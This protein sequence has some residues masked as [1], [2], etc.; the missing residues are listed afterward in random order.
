VPAS[1]LDALVPSDPG[2]FELIDRINRARLKDGARPVPL[3]GLDEAVLNLIFEVLYSCD[4]NLQLCVPGGRQDLATALGIY[5]Q[6]DRRGR[7]MRQGRDPDDLDGPIV[8]LGLNLNVTERLRR[9]RLGTHNLSE[10]LVVGR[11]RGDGNVIGLAGVPS[12]ARAWRH[13]LL[14][15][16]TSLGY[17][18]LAQ[19]RPEVAIID[20]TTLRRPESLARALDWC[21]RQEVRRILLLSEL[22]SEAAAAL[23]VD[24]SWCTFPLTPAILRDVRQT[25][26]VRADGGALST[27]ALII[28]ARR[29]PSAAV[30]RAPA[31]A[32]AR[33]NALSAI[34]A[35]RRIPAPKPQSIQNAV[36]LVNA[37][38]GLW[39]N[40]ATADRIAVEQGRSFSVTGMTR[41][42][43]SDLGRDLHG[44]WATFRETRWTDLRRACLDLAGLVFEENPRLALLQQLLAWA[45]ANRPGATICIRTVSRSGALALAEDLQAVGVGAA[46][47]G[48]GQGPLITVRP[49]GERRP[50]SSTPALEFHLG[51][52]PPW[53]RAGIFA[54]SA[55][56]HV[57]ALEQDEVPWFKSSLEMVSSTWE[58]DLEEVGARTDLEFPSGAGRVAARKVFGPV[59]IDHRGEQEASSELVDLPDFD[60]TGLFAAFTKSVM[61]AVE[62][63]EEDDYVRPIVQARC[64][65]LEPEARRYYVPLDARLEVLIGDDY[66]V[67][68]LADLTP[69]MTVLVSRGESRGNLFTRL[70]LVAHSEVDVRAANLLLD[71]FRKAV[72]DLHEKEG[73]WEKV[74]RAIQ[75][76]GSRVE[77]G[78]ACRAWAMGTSIG[79]DD[80]EDIRRVFWALGNN[81][82]TA[83]GT[84]QRL[85]AIAMQLR[86][87]HG[88]LGQII[89]SAIVE[90]T[91][92]RPGPNC[93]VIAEKCGFD[94]LEVLEEFQVARVR[95]IGNPELVERSQLRHVLPPTETLP[96]A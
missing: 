45:E 93:Q 38:S 72:R 85:G 90:A 5:L 31:L 25:L 50:W 68:P 92:G 42:V 13:G 77:S 65:L 35:A 81:Q 9:I 7:A 23:D 40:P 41:R 94:P 80:V 46:S 63:P 83:D 28:P 15:L 16:N 47:P 11:V 91:R 29:C 69:G 20:G 6:L 75:G 48:D 37:L 51:V 60:L 71:R 95:S 30:Y 22:A 88:G 59:P 12:A 34:A 61:D 55:T 36:R 8:V 24:S 87:M 76:Y 53:R 44:P 4:S 56:E 18:G 73:T 49:Y 54:A 84:W 58:K 19:V 32:L 74:A 2:E 26:A 96:P 27:N 82:M 66:H 78:D 62:D 52:P 21:A 70:K 39:G 43:G 1:Y 64:L 14:Y 89:S 86:H 17:P 3:G 67:L 33:R 57:V 10:A 79:P